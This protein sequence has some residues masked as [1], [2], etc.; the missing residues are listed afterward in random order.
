MLKF[1]QE[2]MF[3]AIQMLEVPILNGL[4][5]RQTVGMLLDFL[6]MKGCQVAE[7]YDMLNTL[8]KNKWLDDEYTEEEALL[9]L[10]KKSVDKLAKLN[11]KPHV[12][13]TPD[14]P[15]KDD[16]HLIDITDDDLPF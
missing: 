4:N 7:A 6:I 11:V 1:T 8:V 10:S 9:S 13:H 12:D 5:N 15:F 2:E 3:N 14:N 16:S